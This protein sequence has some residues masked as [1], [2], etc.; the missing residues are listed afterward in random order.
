[1]RYVAAISDR[2]P[3]GRPSACVSRISPRAAGFRL[4]IGG[5][6]VAA[7][8]CRR[9]L[10]RPLAGAVVC[11]FFAGGVLL[12]GHAWQRAGARP[13]RRVRSARP[14][15]RAQAAHDGRRLPED[16]EAFATVTGTLRAD[17]VQ[18][19]NGV[20]LSVDVDG[21]EGQEGRRGGRG[22]GAGGAIRS[23]RPVTGGVV[24]TVV[25]SLAAER[26]TSWRAGRRVRLPVQLRRPSRYSIPACPTRA[27]AGAARHNA[28]RQR[29]ERRVGGG[30]GTGQ[31]R[32]RGNG[33]G[34]R[35]LAP[36]GRTD[37]WAAGV[38]ARRRSSRRL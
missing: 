31:P 24:V 13:A 30:A 3:R 29:Q 20:S 33:R 14:R 4:V 12:A 7:W 27:R 21:I 9:V 38:R 1:M 36:G 18:T 11:V 8:A 15:E 35:V 6:M 28:R 25:G 32:R 26:I 23:F 37:A 16:D 10:A 19:E 2:A 34:A 22:G 17:A 5:G